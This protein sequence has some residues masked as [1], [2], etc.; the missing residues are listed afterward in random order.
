MKIET[1]TL[2]A[3]YTVVTQHDKEVFRAPRPGHTKANRKACERW[4]EGQKYD[5]DYYRE[6]ARRADAVQR[7]AKENPSARPERISSINRISR[8]W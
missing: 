2:D 3:R 4:V 8:R 6:S 7:W 1:I 5:L